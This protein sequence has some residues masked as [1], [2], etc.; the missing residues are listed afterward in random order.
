[1]PAS[2][3]RPRSELQQPFHY[4]NSHDGVL[5]AAFSMPV[6]MSPHGISHLSHWPSASIATRIATRR[7]CV[8]RILRLIRAANTFNACMAGILVDQWC[9][10]IIFT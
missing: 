2:V 5:R 3:M 9:R 6:S 10:T 7:V 8:W 1:M 4:G